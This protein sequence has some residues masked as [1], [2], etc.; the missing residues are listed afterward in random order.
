MTTT[1]SFLN[2]RSSSFK[3]LKVMGDMHSLRECWA[4][5]L[6]ATNA[7]IRTWSTLKSWKSHE[8][9]EHF[10]FYPTLKSY[11]KDFQKWVSLQICSVG[12]KL[13]HFGS[14]ALAFSFLQL[15][16]CFSSGAKIHTISFLLPSPPPFQQLHSSPCIIVDFPWRICAGLFWGS[17]LAPACTAVIQ[18]W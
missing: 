7:S 6:K 11:E 9:C 12:W 4:L 15:L 8:Q 18:L 3:D 1:L 10:S 5:T 14:A 17:A 16:H 2:K 13:P